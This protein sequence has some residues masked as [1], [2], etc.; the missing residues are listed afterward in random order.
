MEA[1]EQ[2]MNYLDI[3]NSSWLWMVAGL[4]V[5]VVFIQAFLFARK[6]YSTGLEMGL[7]RERMNDAIKSSAPKTTH[8]PF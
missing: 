5:V 6:S 4:A 8:I 1:V 7:T 3:A 2:Q